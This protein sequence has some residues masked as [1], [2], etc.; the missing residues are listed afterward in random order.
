MDQIARKTR[1]LMGIVLISVPTIAY[2]GY[3]LLGILTRQWELAVSG[4]QLTF[5][6]A[7]HGHAGVLLIL[8]L[9]ALGLV[10]RARLP[11]WLRWVVRLG[12]PTA[13]LLVSAGFFLSVLFGDG[14]QVGSLVVLI[15]IGAFLLAFAVISLGIGLIRKPLADSSRGS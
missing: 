15:Y 11:E 3:F 5:F 9:I 7:G 4:L 2:G 10:D 8:S 6:R 12:M 14:T 1:V 13:A